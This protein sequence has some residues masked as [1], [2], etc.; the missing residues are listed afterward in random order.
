MYITRYCPYCIRDKALL[1]EKGIPYKEIRVDE[2]ISKRDEMTE[3]S[4]RRTVPQIWVGD[5]HVGGYTDLYRFDNTGEL[6]DLLSAE[7]S[8]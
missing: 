5:F 1:D 4:G 3:R 2:D 7:G 6:D 8:Q